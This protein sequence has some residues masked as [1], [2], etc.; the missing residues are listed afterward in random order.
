MKILVAHASNY[1]YQTEL[2]EPLKQSALAK[3]HTLIFPHDAENVEIETSSHIPDAGL[4]IAEVSYPSTGAGIEI[5]LAQAANVP[6]LF[7]HKT[8]TT[9]SSALKFITGKVI[10]YKDSAD[11][12]SKIESE[13]RA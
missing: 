12:V 3:E 10:E 8:G 1:D 11:L 7:M 13:L 5:G 6:T 4:M 9:P 2:Y